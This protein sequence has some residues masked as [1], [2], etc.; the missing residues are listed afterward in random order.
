LNTPDIIEKIKKLLRLSR[1]SNRHEAELALSRAAELATR[2]KID[3]ASVD[4]DADSESLGHEFFEMGLRV[5]FLQHRALN[6]CVRFFHVEVCIY[7]PRVVFVGTPTD[8][9][10]ANYVCGF[11][12]QQGRRFLRE[13]EAEERKARLKV[14]KNKRENFIQG[15]IYGIAANLTEAN[16]FAMD[17]A[18]FAIVL[19]EQK[20]R[21][22]AAMDALIP[23]RETAQRII[24]R[25]N[26]TA[27]M[28]GWRK[29]KETKIAP[30]INPAREQLRLH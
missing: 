13:W 28:A 24:K 8:I 18:K 4:P 2:H 19:A 22:S 10:I 29:G 30:A 14:T 16:R 12:Q 15:F 6:I 1:S 7:R 25:E 23:N 9:A 5:S 26:T 27:I 17:D 11:L 20:S 21:R 3:L